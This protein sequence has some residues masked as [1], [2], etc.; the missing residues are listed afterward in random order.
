MELKRIIREPLLLGFQL[1]FPGVLVLIF[2]LLLSSISYSWSE[3]SIFEIMVP[4]LFAYASTLTITSV[5][6]SIASGRES[7]I[8]RR[9]NT[10]P[11]TS[12][13]VIG[14]QMLSYTIISLMQLAILGSTA[15]I[16][17]FRPDTTVAA[18]PLIFFFLLFLTFCSV[19][20]GQITAILAKTPQTAGSLAFI[21]IV[22]QQL[23][24]TFIYMGEAAKVIGVIMPSYYVTD[25]LTLIFDGAPLTD[26]NIWMD[27]AVIFI[28][29]IAIF[30]I[31]TIL[32]GKYKNK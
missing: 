20:F 32:Y 15:L 22:P 25:A 24:G 5:A 29:G 18:L 23:F 16:I 26:L 13:E 2:G 27:F 14:S 30:V 28:I 21:F 17:G 7:G 9:M 10:T 1:L 3:K 4:G 6:T 8:E 31:G 19:G 11:I 12:G